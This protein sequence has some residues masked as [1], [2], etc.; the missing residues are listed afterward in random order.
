VQAPPERN[1]LSACWTERLSP[2]APG[3]EVGGELGVSFRSV[4]MR[5]PAGTSIKETTMSPL[6]ARM[7]ERR[8]AGDASASTF[9]SVIVCRLREKLTKRA[10]ARISRR[11]FVADKRGA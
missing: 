3:S 1:K 10:A 9:R 5:L 2:R 4:G 11:L 6:R 8:S 7:I